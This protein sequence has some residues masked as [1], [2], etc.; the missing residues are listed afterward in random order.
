MSIPTTYFPDAEI[1]QYILSYGIV[2]VAEGLTESF[3][4]P[5]LGL[6]SFIIQH[7]NS[8]GSAVV[9]VKE[10][11]LLKDKAIASGQVTTTVYGY[12]S[13]KIKTI[14]VF[15]KPLGMFQ[16]FGCNMHMLTNSSINLFLLLGEEKGNELLNKLKDTEDNLA[17]INILNEFFKK[18]KPVTINTTEIT[19]VLDFIH[20]H[21]GN[22]SVKKIEAHCYAHRKSIER[23]F[24][25]QV[26][27][28]PKVYANIYRF[29][30]LMNYLQHHPQTPWLQLSN[31]TGYYD[32]SHM[33]RYFKEYLKASP[34]QLVSLDV[35]FNNY[36][37]NRFYTI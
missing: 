34:N 32:Q 7:Q 18:Q 30:C 21:Q 35:D 4:S 29:K 5:P 16:L 8:N 10:I 13:G 14:L 25:F 23:H 9:I 20:F 26:G 19:R 12:Y 15:F 1:S 36:L 31:L 17:L 24:Q 28:S 3:I 22:I 33:L 27:L 37:L 2:E 11:N 6:S